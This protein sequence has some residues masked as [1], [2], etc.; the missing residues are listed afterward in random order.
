M[1]L[2]HAAADDL[3]RVSTICESGRAHANGTRVE[4]M[5]LVDAYDRYVLENV[6]DAFDLDSGP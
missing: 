6:F 1:F 2:H 5:A 3:C 4:L